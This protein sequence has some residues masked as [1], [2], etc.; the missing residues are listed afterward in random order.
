MVSMEESNKL[1]EHSIVMMR[2]AY[3]AITYNMKEGKA[4]VDVE[5]KSQ[6]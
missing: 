5:G 4:N 1:L 2:P 6:S 3:N